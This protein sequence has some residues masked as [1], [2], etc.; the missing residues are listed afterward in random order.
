VLFVSNLPCGLALPISSF[1]VLL[2]GGA[3]P[4]TSALH[5]PHHPPGGRLPLRDVRGGDASSASIRTKRV[6]CSDLPRVKSELSCG[7][8]F[9]VSFTSALWYTSMNWSSSNSMRREAS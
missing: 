1:F 7:S 3:R 2:L 6:L 9:L 4:P 5:A 8:I